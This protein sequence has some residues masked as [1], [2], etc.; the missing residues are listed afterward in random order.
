MGRGRRVAAPLAGLVVCAVLFVH[1]R[2]LDDLAGPDRL[3]P[4]FWPRLALVGLGLACLGRLVGAWR[5]AGPGPEIGEPPPELRRERLTA[6]IALVLAYVA[7]TPVVGF[8]LA[9]AGFVA[10]FM[11]MAGARS[12]PGIAVTAVAGTAGLLHLFVRLVYLP[13]PKG[14]GPFEALTLALYR[15]LRIF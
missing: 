13:L 5:P 9:T 8:P 6:A 12:A 2:S 15:A 1:T 10:G 14:D 4:G 3:G 11:W 7:A